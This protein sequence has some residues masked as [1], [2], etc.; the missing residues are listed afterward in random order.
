MDKNTN[1]CVTDNNMV[2]VIVPIYN[3]ESYLEACVE[4]I[5]AQTYTNIEIILV[6]DG[7]VDNSGKICDEYVKKDN[8]IRVIHKNNE[9]VSVARNTALTQVKGEFIMFVDADDEIENDC[10]EKL[11][12]KQRERDFDFVAGAC[13]VL[14][15]KK[16][17]LSNY[18]NKEYFGDEIKN[19]IF[20]ILSLYSISAPW[21]KLFK[22]SIIQDNVSFIKNV[23]Y[24]EDAMFLV[25]YLTHAMSVAIIDDVIYRYNCKNLSC[26]SQKFHPDMCEYHKLIIKKV[27]MMI[28]EDNE[29]AKEN[30]QFKNLVLR[31]VEWVLEHYLYCAGWVKET[32]GF[33]KKTIQLFGDFI[34]VELLSF[35][36]KLLQYLKDEK[37]TKFV[38][39][40][41]IKNAFRYCRFKIKKFLKQIV[42]KYGLLK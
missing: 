26:A 22:K 30:K 35:D 24:G 13:I 3:A 9:G 29:K 31:R 21:G 38:L 40:W 4:S 41:R 16:N 11:V 25:D 12:K 20:E 1:V 27:Q 7:S 14:G 28:S 8:R 23:T 32:S 19:S 5:L 37:Y 10:V 39:S 36:N 15:R 18:L 6:D 33:V 42:I 17:T 2:S 34:N